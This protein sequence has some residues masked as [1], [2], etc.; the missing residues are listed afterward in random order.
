M[1][2]FEVSIPIADSQYNERIIVNK[3]GD[4]YSLVLGREG[5]GNG[6]VYMQWGFPQGSDKQPR[7]KAIPWKIPLGNYVQAQAMLKALLAVFETPPRKAQAVD[8]ALP[9]NEDIPF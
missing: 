4:Q 5:K 6:T 7:N 1:S 8:K 9:V 3:Y 2:E